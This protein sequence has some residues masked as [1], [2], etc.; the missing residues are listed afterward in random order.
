MTEEWF[1]ADEEV[2]GSTSDMMWLNSSIGR[3][4]LFKPDISGD[5]YCIET[6]VKAVADFFGIPCSDIIPYTFNDIDG[7]LSI[8]TDTRRYH[9]I[10][11]A[12]LFRNGS[13][14]S[15]N[16]I[17]A[18][19]TVYNEDI[20]FS[21]L[22]LQQTVSDGCFEDL[23]KMCFLDAIVRN[24]DRHIGNIDFLLAY[25]SK[26]ILAVAPLFDN[27][28]SLS[29]STTESALFGIDSTRVWKHRDIFA[30]LLQYDFMKQLL[31][32]ANSLQFKELCNNLEY[33]DFIYE[34]ACNFLHSMVDAAKSSLRE[35]KLI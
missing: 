17:S 9:R 28:M 11:G 31:F 18:G 15:S 14:Y 3:R 34:R 24:Q 1:S 35:M 8:V 19:N 20:D 5:D 23:C 29:N 16:P 2:V 7:F 22:G 6:N 26:L 33:G 21:L 30:H 27:V 25:D 13:K 4:A 10:N 12:D 32:Q